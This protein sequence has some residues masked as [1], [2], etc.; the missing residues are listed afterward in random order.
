MV[1]VFFILALMTGM[2]GGWQTLTGVHCLWLFP[3]AL[4]GI[5]LGDTCLYASVRRLGP[6]RTGILF[7]TNAPMTLFM[8]WLFLGETIPAASLAGC[9]LITIGVILA[10]LGRGG[11]GQ[12]HDWEMVHGS[13]GAGMLIGLG[14][15]L[16]Q[17]LGSLLAKPALA[18]GADPVAAS[19]LRVGAGAVALLATLFCRGAPF[20]GLV[21]L[22]L[23]MTGWILASGLVG[24]AM[25]MTLLLYGLAHGPTGIVASLS[26][27]S[28]VLILPVLWLATGERPTSG[29]WVG[30]FLAVIGTGLI[31]NS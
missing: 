28:P 20:H 4:I 8:G 26:A 27:T 6:R 30:A 2:R 5:F 11:P 21:P 22:T 13:L 29:A 24:M 23:R 3:S 16:C 19:A 12:R 1:L 17:A 31:F 10:V 7:T 9:L 14:A 15:A 18:D 25:G